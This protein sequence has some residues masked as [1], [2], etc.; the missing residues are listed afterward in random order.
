MTG[1]VDVAHFGAKSGGSDCRARLQ[2]AFDYA[3][4]L[5]A[6]VTDFA[7][8]AATFSVPTVM[9]PPGGRFEIDDPGLV[10][11]PYVRIV[12][13]HTVLYSRS[14]TSPIVTANGYVFD[15]E[16][17]IFVGGNGH[18][19]LTGSAYMQN[20]MRARIRDCRFNRTATGE[21]SL[22]FAPLDPAWAATSTLSMFL[23]MRGCYHD[24]CLAFQGGAD[25]ILIEDEI[26]T[27]TVNDGPWING[28]GS[29]RVRDVQGVPIYRKSEGGE[30]I[31]STN[32]W[33]K[34]RGSLDCT[35]FRFGGENGGAR[36]LHY[37]GGGSGA[38]E[39]H[40]DV[41]R[42][43]SNQMH[44]AYGPWALFEGNFPS[45]IV[46][47]N[48]GYMPNAAVVDAEAEG[49][50]RRLTARGL[51]VRMDSGAPAISTKFC[52][53][54]GSEIHALNVLQ[55]SP[56]Q[57]ST[58][59]HNLIPAGVVDSANITVSSNLGVTVDGSD[60]CLGQTLTGWRAGENGG[61]AYF[62]MADVL[63]GVPAG[64]YCF[65]FVVRASQGCQIYPTLEGGTV[66][67]NV[68]SVDATGEEFVRL[69]WPFHHDGAST[70]LGIGLERIPANGLV[71][72]GLFELVVGAEPSTE[73]EVPS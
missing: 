53:P 9:L 72:F 41:V 69:A 63:F 6:G 67:G 59:K 61:G 54:D 57:K 22:R 10:L 17:I 30:N 68:E 34:H 37:V 5:A 44:C 65:S 32:P 29:L 25:D 45:L 51:R 56:A 38:D 19:K 27:W 46:E 71:F 47:P 1:I 64:T 49:S 28:S 36:I 14:T 66:I 4:S 2:S 50:L 43:H 55:G 39:I 48:S 15:C 26:A 3:A 52:R 40:N 42:F 18:I 12:G 11:P 33:L 58:A 70:N 8:Y 31:P 13:S 73:Y 24:G 23:A 62:S 20:S 60:S 21:Y 7:G 35:G 16:G